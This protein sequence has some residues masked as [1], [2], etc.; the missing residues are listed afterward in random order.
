MLGSLE[1]YQ[2]NKHP[3]LKEELWKCIHNVPWVL[4]ADNSI[5]K[6]CWQNGRTSKGQMVLKCLQVGNCAIRSVLRASTMP[7]FKPHSNAPESI[8][9]DTEDTEVP[10]P[11][12]RRGWRR[13]AGV[14]VDLTGRL[15]LTEVH[16]SGCRCLL[17]PIF[18]VGDICGS[19]GWREFQVEG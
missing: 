10:C 11:T 2:R 13:E 12:A 7:S 6:R 18:K 3:A 1:F 4:G 15:Q 5:V 19:A 16:A 8:F 9:R 17:T 14:T